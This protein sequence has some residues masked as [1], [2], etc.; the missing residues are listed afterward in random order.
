MSKEL[1]RQLK[2]LRGGEVNPRAAWLRGN[3][4][5]LLSQIKNTVPSAPAEETVQLHDIWTILSIFLP[6]RLVYSVVRPVS[7]LLVI[8]LIAT[9]GWIATVDAAY[10]ALPGDWL[11][12]AK[13][14][15]EKTRVVVAAVMGDNKAESKLH[16][17]FAKRRA[18]EAKKVLKGDDSSSR[19]LKIITKS[20]AD[21]KNEI[22]N[23]DNKLEEIKTNPAD[24]AA[25]GVA[26]DIKK[27]TEQIK[28]VLQE[29]KEGLS[30]STSTE[31]KILS[32]EVSEVKDLVKDASIK[33]VELMVAKHLE[34]DNSV[35]KE[36]VKQV[37]NTALQTAATEVGESQQSVEGVKKVVEAVKTEV[38][39]L[40][41]ENI[42]QSAEQAAGAQEL[43]RKMTEVTSQTK[44]AVVK[45][46]AVSA[47][48][49]KKITEARELLSSGEL[50]RAV[51][52]AR[53]VT[54]ASKEAEKITDNTLKNVQE[55]LPILPIV[56][57]VKGA[58]AVDSAPSST[59]AI[60]VIITTTTHTQAT[61][62]KAPP[63]EGF[64]LSNQ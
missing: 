21:L 15:A 43:S 61:V 8:T 18:A 31:N 25:A 53:E 2:N 64:S 41:R 12:P 10:E 34:G 29:V 4:E 45:T 22:K 36:E 5:L 26:K 62:E 54:E 48:V 11:Y 19:K 57:V 58:T 17:E 52:K 20:V 42:K 59:T 6:P 24:Q 39:G 9:S 46:E 40:A 35:S 47:E 16:V 32:Q 55:V 37:I 51:D 7:V 33:A 27:D 3:R 23:V 49:D 56:N 1:I 28:N 44:E 13:R 60:I 38:Q 14:A 50:T 30:T 63:K